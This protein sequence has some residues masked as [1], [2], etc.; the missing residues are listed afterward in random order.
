VG[1]RYLVMHDT[2]AISPR[3]PPPLL[4]GAVTEP[5]NG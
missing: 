2:G 5:I 4:S 1:I 3:P